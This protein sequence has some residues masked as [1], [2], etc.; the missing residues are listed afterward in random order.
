MELGP[1]DMELSRKIDAYDI[2]SYVAAVSVDWDVVAKDYAGYLDVVSLRKDVC[3]RAVNEMI[4][5]V[6]TDPELIPITADLFA[7]NGIH[8]EYAGRTPRE[9]V[10]YVQEELRK[11]MAGS[12]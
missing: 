9:F 7:I 3:I 6:L 2:A 4:P 8:E 10:L 12:E 5:Q 11:R 1:E